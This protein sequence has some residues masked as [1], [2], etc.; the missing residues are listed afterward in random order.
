MAN[1]LLIHGSW[2][3]AWCW[4]RLLPLLKADGHRATAIDL[5]AHGDDRRFPWFTSLRGYGRRIVQAARAL[6]EKPVLVGHSMGG[7]AITDAAAREPTAFAGLVYVCA[8]APLPGDSL[9]ALG[10]RDPATLV[11][12][13]TGLSF[14]GVRIRPERARDVFYGACDEADAARA[15]ERLRPDPVPPLLQRLRHGPPE[16]LPRAYVEC[17][18]DRAIS[19]GQQRML[20]QRAGVRRVVTLEADHSP[21]LS[22]PHEL[23][24]RLGEL[25]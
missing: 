6:E 22:A 9:L 19:I 7:L 10:Q 21:F 1:F 3:G 14:G 4:E 12:T 24:A 13:S 15:T 25:S 5:P 17:T 8:Y 20:A 18:E 2:H 16:R 23:A 11:P